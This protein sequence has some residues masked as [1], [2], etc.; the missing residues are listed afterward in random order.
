M[1]GYMRGGAEGEIEPLPE[2]WYDTGDI[3]GR[4]PEGFLR[5]KG[6]AK[7]FAKIGGEMVSLGAIEEFAAKISPAFRH[8]AVTKPDTRKGELVVL[9]TEDPALTRDE[10]RKGAGAVGIPE[11]MFPR[12]VI[13]VAHIPVLGTGKTDYPS[14][15][16]LA[17]EMSAAA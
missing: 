12:E 1:L 15:L 8:A 7:R 2:G 3:V 16:R 6:R 4:D 13:S 17:A 5:I 10:Y 11:I 9:F 14:V